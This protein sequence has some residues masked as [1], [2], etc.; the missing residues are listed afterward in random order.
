MLK[1]RRFVICLII[2][3]VLFSCKDST[4]KLTLQENLPIQ[5]EEYTLS[6][7]PVNSDLNGPI[8]MVYVFDY[9]EP[10][11]SANH[12]P[13]KLFE[14]VL[15][16]GDDRATTIDMAK[17]GDN[18]EATIA[19]PDNVCLLSW[20]F[21]DGENNDY[22]NK[23]TYTSYIYNKKGIPVK[24]ARFRNIDFL[25][26]AKESPERIIDEVKAE[27]T[28]YP[29][30]WT[31][32]I[33]YRR[34]IFENA[35]TLEELNKEMVNAR[36][37][38]DSMVKNF[39]E[40]DSLK[41]V[42]AAW[43]IDY[44]RNVYRPVQK[45]AKN[46]QEEFMEIMATV[47]LENQWGSMKQYYTSMV[48]GENLRR[49]NIAFMRNI[50]G[51]SAPD[52]EFETIDGKKGKLSD[53]RGNYML[54]EFWSVGCGPCIAEIPNLK[55]TL[56]K[57]G[58]KGFDILSICM[59]RNMAEDKFIEFMDEKE[60]TWTTVLEGDDPSISKRYK[61]YGV[62]TFFLI[63]PEGKVVNLGA[64]IRGERLGKKL[65]EFYQS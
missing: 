60:I 49:E 61:I 9:W 58:P 30:N 40:S 44:G 43:L 46:S 53:Y 1:K 59:T 32:Q 10:I 14:N 48:E 39:G 45:L 3:I 4:D 23:K 16:T 34:K 50:K 7:T 35:E 6:Y 38:Y 12:G 5:G 65:S 11:Y 20:Y 51:N 13:D 28:D 63:D 21:T 26:M 36:K 19:I 8:K 33:I 15:S 29:K 64:E 54:L 22:N 55:E 18:W 52:F 25:E 17:S 24:N 57:F 56:E 42:L 27:V 47:P 41:Q 31:S 2:G 37:D 62:P